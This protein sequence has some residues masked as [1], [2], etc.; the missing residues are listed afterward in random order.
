MMRA[1][2]VLPVL[3]LAGCA[4]LPAW[5]E[6]PPPTAADGLRIACDSYDTTLEAITVQRRLGHLSGDQVVAVSEAILVIGSLCSE[7]A[8][9]PA[10]ALDAVQEQLIRMIEIKE[11]AK[12]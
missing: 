1:G 12:R 4:G 8:S 9:D 5:P 2:A 3:V 6:G 10:A 7:P 11:A